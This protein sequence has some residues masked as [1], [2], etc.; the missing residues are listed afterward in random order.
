MSFRAQQD[1]PLSQVQII[2]IRLFLTRMRNRFKETIYM[3]TCHIVDK[4]KNVMGAQR[5]ISLFQLQTKARFF[6]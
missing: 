6:A 3:E 1:V 5:S 4:T 2:I